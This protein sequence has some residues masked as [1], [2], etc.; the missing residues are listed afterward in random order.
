MREPILVTSDGGKIINTVSG[1]FVIANK[2]RGKLLAH[3]AHPLLGDVMTIHSHRSEIYA[4]VS[5]FIFIREYWI[6]YQVDYTNKTI[7]FC[8]DKDVVTKMNNII[9][10]KKNIESNIKY[11]RFKH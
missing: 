7:V 5:L 11:Q 6:F 9:K 8:D 1:S 10:N 3:N 2:K 4:Q